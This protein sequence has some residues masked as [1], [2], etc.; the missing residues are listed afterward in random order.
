MLIIG[1][2][3]YTMVYAGMAF[4]SR[5][6]FFYLLFLLYG[7]Y[8]AATEGIA[9]AWITNVCSSRD[10]ATA[11]G[12]YTG[13]QS[14]G[15]MMASTIAGWL[16]LGWGAK[17]TFLVTASAAFLVVLYLALNRAIRA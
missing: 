11:I 17:V 8:A 16:W 14:I 3:I 9:K 2:L 5:T 6:E 15:A 1:F 10:T 13:F 7:I 4:A 12:T